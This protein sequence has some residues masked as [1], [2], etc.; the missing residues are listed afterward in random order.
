M[1]LDAQAQGHHTGKIQMAQ[2]GW[3]LEMEVEQQAAV[4]GINR[5]SGEDSCTEL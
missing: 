3:H 1:W 4:E 5:L 2:H